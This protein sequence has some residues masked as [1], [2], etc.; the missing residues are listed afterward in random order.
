MKSALL[1]CFLFSSLLSAQQPGVA[2]IWETS[3]NI[4]QFVTGAVR[5]KPLLEQMKPQEWVAQGASQTYVTQ[6]DGARLELDY[7]EQAAKLF[8]TEPERL[9]AAL[10]TY[11][12]WQNVEFRMESLIEAVR[13]YQNPAVGD[14]ILGV[15]RSNTGNRDGL[16]NYIAQLAELKEREAAV[17]EE[18][19]QR[20]RADLLRPAAPAPKTTPPAKRNTQ[21]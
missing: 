14:L 20:C 19:A 18:E 2:A 21:K 7:L 6:W 11:F 17:S 4:G 8:Q 9:T 13:K 12:R 16:R 5:L 15:L 1:A 10:D 3:E